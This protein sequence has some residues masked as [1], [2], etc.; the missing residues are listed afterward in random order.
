MDRKYR[1]AKLRL[2]AKPRAH[3]QGGGLSFSEMERMEIVFNFKHILDMVKVKIAK[4]PG[5]HLVP[6]PPAINNKSLRYSLSNP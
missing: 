3:A 1:L 4:L 6:K 5:S 2:R